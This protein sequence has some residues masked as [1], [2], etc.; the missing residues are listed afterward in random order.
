MIS[1][2]EKKKIDNKEFIYKNIN[3][4]KS[5]YYKKIN[6]NEEKELNENMDRPKSSRIW[7]VPMNDLEADAIIRMLIKN[8]EEFYTTGQKWGASWDGLEKETKMIIIDAK[9]NALDIYGEEQV[10]YG[11][12]LQG[13]MEGTINID[14]HTYGND[15]RSNPKSSIEQ[16]AEILGVELTLDERFIAAN[17]K[18]FI[19]AMEKLGEELGITGKDL[20]EIIKNIRLRDRA[21]QGITLEQEVQAQE[22]VEKLGEINEKKD[23]ILVDSLPHSKTSTITDRLY[24]KYENLLVTST[25]GETNFYGSAELI[26]ILN[27]KFPGGWSGGQLDQGNGFW[28][29]YADQEAIKKTVQEYIERT[30]QLKQTPKE[31]DDKTHDDE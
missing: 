30:R 20:Q 8:G 9:E 21:A 22:A 27:E 10:I 16:V 5:N 23:Y 31:N 17:D 25:D 18:G 4:N 6:I 24:G 11:V 19:P 2:P 28:G 12:E 29:G 26:G 14:H 7:I 1:K 3:T 15:D 13:K